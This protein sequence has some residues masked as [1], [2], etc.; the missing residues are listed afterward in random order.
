MYSMTFI[1][2]MHFFLS[3]KKSWTSMI[4]KSLESHSIWRELPTNWHALC[5]KVSVAWNI[6][7]TFQLLL[8]S[9]TIKWEN[10]CCYS[11]CHRL[12]RLLLTMFC[13]TEQRKIIEINSWKRQST[14]N[15]KDT[16]PMGFCDLSNALSSSKIHK[17]GCLKECQGVSTMSN[18]LISY[19]FAYFIAMGENV[20]SE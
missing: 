14:S 13:T 16:S 18:S 20:E 7:G 3:Q 12:A 1:Q 5:W 11:Y 15:I 6:S 10:N 19:L 2:T 8:V 17:V 4:E 9:S